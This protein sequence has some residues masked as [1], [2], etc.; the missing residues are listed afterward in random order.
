MATTAQ[1]TKA[2]KGLGMEGPIARWY[3]RNTGKVL[4]Q[5]QRAARDAAASLKGGSS[6]LEV[7]PGPGYFA[8]ALAGLGSFHIVGLDIS[9]SFV[10]IASGNARLAGVDVEF[11][12]GDASATP[13]DDD[14][15]DFIYCRAAFKNFS[16]PV[17]ALEEM[18]RVLRPD[19]RAVISDLRRDASAA[20]IHA[21]VE[22]MHLGRINTVLT[23]WIF[24]YSLLKRAY[25]PDDLR[26][27][28]S[29]TPFGACEIEPESIGMEVS[30]RK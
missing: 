23:R 6:V 19:G 17:G 21:A 30:F 11:Q 27:M 12:Q 7:A 14:S 1:R 22:G 25:L 2:Y 20:D 3:T 10:E 28:A 13:F 15:F 8:I 5:Y 16:D 26:H 4:D 29:Q 18:H 24:R 9:R